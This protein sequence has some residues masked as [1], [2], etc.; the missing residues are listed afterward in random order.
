MDTKHFEE[1][2]TEEIKVH[3]K[4][5]NI[6]THTDRNKIILTT[7]SVINIIFLTVLVL[8]V[9]RLTILQKNL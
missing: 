3:K 8:G 4:L 6:K 9:I 5:E 2:K 1:D 7:L